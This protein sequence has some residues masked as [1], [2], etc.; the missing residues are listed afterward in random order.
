MTFDIRQVIMEQNDTAHT[1][2]L[3]EAPKH[4]TGN[5]SDVDIWDSKRVDHAIRNFNDNISTATASLNQIEGFSKKDFKD[6]KIDGR[7]G[8]FVE[9]FRKMR[10][11][12]DALLD[13]MNRFRGK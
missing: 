13:E 1:K 7:I 4:V 9:T 6:R 5:P 8:K 11:D 10:I 3:D 12:F 2:R